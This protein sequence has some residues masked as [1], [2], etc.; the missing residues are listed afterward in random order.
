MPIKRTNPFAESPGRAGR[1]MAPGSLGL[2]PS[3]RE[4]LKSSA[5]GMGSL[6]ASWLLW[7][8]LM[9]L[10][11]LLQQFSL[12]FQKFLHKQTEAQLAECKQ[13]FAYS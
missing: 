6:A 2:L 11:E 12:P 4:L 13:S 10:L 7:C 9:W 3:R 1:P 5:L 8:F